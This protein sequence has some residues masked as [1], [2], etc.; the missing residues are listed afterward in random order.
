MNLKGLISVLIVLALSFF[1]VF[2]C[3]KEQGKDEEKA[4]D[5]VKESGKNYIE[6][7]SF[8]IFFDEEGTKRTKV[9]EKG[10]KEFKAYIII[11]FP[12]YM[13]IAATEFRLALPEGIELE[14]NRSNPN[15]YIELGGFEDGLS[16]RI[17]CVA[18]PKLVLHTLTLKVTKEVKNAEL[19]VLPARRS[20]FLGVCTCEE[21]YPKVSATSYKA[22]INPEE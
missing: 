16:E 8:G 10:E 15:K 11:S 21:G 1:L 14:S 9:L 20:L 19:A 6:D 13:E 4:A 7:V 3:S 12:D 18:G 17:K 22:V 2:S 5:E